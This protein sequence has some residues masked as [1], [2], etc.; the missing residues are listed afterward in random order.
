MQV[1]RLNIMVIL[2]WQTS[3]PDGPCSEIEKKIL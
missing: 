1:L 3:L 2:E